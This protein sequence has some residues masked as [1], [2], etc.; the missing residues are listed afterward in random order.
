MKDIKTYLLESK[1]DIIRFKIDNLDDELEI[2]KVSKSR[3]NEIKNFFNTILGEGPYY[4]ISRNNIKGQESVKITVSKGSFELKELWDENDEWAKLHNEKVIEHNKKI[5]A[6]SKEMKDKIKSLENSVVGLK[7]SKD[8]KFG[9]G[10]GKPTS[11]TGGICEFEGN[12]IPCII[13][14]QDLY[15]NDRNWNQYI[16]TIYLSCKDID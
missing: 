7:L 5:E 16:R 6:L 3:R 10:K 8:F 2:N 4:C 11:L 14:I 1:D 13:Q 12:Y 9:L 15:A